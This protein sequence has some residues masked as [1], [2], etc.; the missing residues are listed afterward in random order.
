MH[1]VLRGI[2]RRDE[3]SPLARL[4]LVADT[5]VI[6][7]QSGRSFLVYGMVPLQ[8][9]ELIV[10]RSADMLRGSGFAVGCSGKYRGT[11]SQTPVGKEV[12]WIII[13]KIFHVEEPNLISPVLIKINHQLHA[14]LTRIKYQ[15]QTTVI[16]YIHRF[17]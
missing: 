16:V 1:P 3:I 6:T 11:V 10:L 4:P 5:D 7:H 15:I 13:I 9:H 17:L 2:V 12:F 14:F 8:G